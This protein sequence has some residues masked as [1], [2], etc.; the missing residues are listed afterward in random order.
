MIQ[1][2]NIAY[3]YPNQTTS[4]IEGFDLSIEAGETILIEGAN[5]S[6]KT[7]LLRVMAGIVPQFTG[8]VFSGKRT[9]MGQDHDGIDCRNFGMVFHGNDQQFIQSRVDQEI[10]FMLENQN[11][12][13]DEIQT[14]FN[15]L[16]ESFELQS[17]TDREIHTLSSGERQILKIA[18]AWIM[19]PKILLMDE[20]LSYLD[21]TNK[22]KILGLLLKLQ[23]TQQL[24]FV[25]ADHQP[26]HWN[27]FDRVRRV[28]LSPQ[29]TETQSSTKQPFT[30]G[31]EIIRL[32][33]VSFKYAD[34]P[35]INHFT[36]SVHT[37]ERIVISGVNGSGKT[38]LLQI[39]SGQLSPVK[40]EVHFLSPSKIKILPTS[41]MEYLFSMPVQDEFELEGKKVAVYPY[42]LSDFEKQ[43]AFDLS[44]GQ[45][46]KVGL[47]LIFDETS[48]IILLDEPFAHLDEASR[49]VL[50]QTME[51]WSMQGKTILF[52]A[53]DASLFEPWVSQV[54]SL[55]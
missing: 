23:R 29:V 16:V 34:R 4:I 39:L 8:G 1:L 49:Q 12:A 36:K 52:T 13:K 35:L 17:Y 3:T 21:E 7:T 30:L 48:N 50:V 46:K 42:D 19:S 43:Y 40:G 28:Q 20:P 53:H 9:L 6:G 2:Q 47:N 54:W 10:L 37:G 11:F 38:T 41:S 18:M 26:D 31:E 45:Q 22:K 25:I 32:Q 5:G 44:H 27:G 24:T 33:D 55:S 14:R 51:T 15:Q